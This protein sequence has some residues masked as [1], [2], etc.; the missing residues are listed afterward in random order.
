LFAL[1][2]DGFT[3]SAHVEA[4]EAFASRQALDAACAVIDDEAVAGWAMAS[5][6]FAR[7]GRPVILLTGFLQRVPAPPLTRFV[8]KP[9]LG[10][11]LVNAVRDAVASVL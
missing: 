3:V 2:S 10:E 8:M 1:E 4:A 6:Q 7:F 9:F 11:P 5:R